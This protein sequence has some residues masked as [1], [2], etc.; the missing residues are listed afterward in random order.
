M[1]NS[2]VIHQ[3]KISVLFLFLAIVNRAPINKD[4]WESLQSVKDTE[5]TKPL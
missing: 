1:Y 4:K 3:L 2:F 5:N